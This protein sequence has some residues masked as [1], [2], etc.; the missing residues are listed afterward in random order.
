M[1]AQRRLKAAAHRLG[2]SASD[3]A[4]ARPSVDWIS[5][6]LARVLVAGLASGGVHFEEIGLGATLVVVN[7]HFL[8][9]RMYEGDRR[10]LFLN[11]LRF[12]HPGRFGVG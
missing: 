7:E 6:A 8:A 3:A 10:I 11:C 5:L 1:W 2:I 4:S 9:E 12:V